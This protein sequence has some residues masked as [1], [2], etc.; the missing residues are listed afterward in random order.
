MKKRQSRILGLLL[1]AVMVGSS[2]VPSSALAADSAKSLY[3]RAV[4][5][6]ENDYKPGSPDVEGIAGGYENEFIKI[7]HPDKDISRKNFDPTDGPEERKKHESEVFADGLLDYVGNKRVEAPGTHPDAKGQGDR[8]QTYSW[9]GFAYGDWMYV[10]TLFSSTKTT[11]ELLGVE[12]SRDQLDKSYGGDLYTAEFDEQEPG[13][14]LSKINVK[15][16]EVKI[17][18]S[19]AKNGL[20][21]SFRSAVEYKDKLYFCGSVNHLPSIY[22]VDPKTDAFQCVYQD[23]SIRNHPGGPGQ[24]WAESLEK[25]ICPTIRGISVYK[26]YLVISTVGIDG[27]PYIAVSNDPSSGQFTKIASAWEDVEKKIPGELLGYPACRIQDSIMGGSIWEMVEF[28]DK[29]YVAIAT[30]TPEIA[31][32]NGGTHV[33]KDEDGN[34]VLDKDGNPVQ[35]IDEM[36]S[37]AIITGTFD[38]GTKAHPNSVDDPTAWTWE[39]LVGDKKDGAKYPFGIDPER[40]RSSACNM[41]V[42]KDKLYIGE[43]TDTQIAFLNMTGMEFDY[44]A[45]NLEQS[46][47]LY[48]MDKNEDIEKVMGQPTK[49]FPVAVSG[50]NESGFGRRENQYIWQ[51][52]VFNDKLYLGTFDETA[53][54]YPL[55]DAAKDAMS[56]Q[57]KEKLEKGL[58]EIEKYAEELVEQNKDSEI[59]QPT[60]LALPDEKV[61]DV[62]KNEADEEKAEIK[63]EVKEEAKEELKEEV[64]ENEEVKLAQSILDAKSFYE[65]R[66]EAGLL[67]DVVNEKSESL[68][69]SSL[70]ENGPMVEVES[71]DS[72][73]LAL[74]MINDMVTPSKDA[75]VREKLASAVQF[76]LLNEEVNAYVNSKAE[77]PSF[78]AET[79]KDTTG[80]QINESVKALLKVLQY[81][82]DCIPGFDMYVTEDGVHFKQITRSG[83]GDSYNQGLRVFAANN[84]KENPWLCIGTANPFY[85]TQIWRMEDKVMKKDP[86]DPKQEIVKVKFIRENGDQAERR[87]DTPDEIYVNEGTKE[88]SPDELTIMLPTDTKLKD[89][90][91]VKIQVDENGQKFVEVNVLSD[92]KDVTLRFLDINKAEEEQV[93]GT[94][95]IKVGRSK[96]AVPEAE[97]AKVLPNGYVRADE[98]KVEI[99]EQGESGFYADVPVLKSGEAHPDEK[100]SVSGVVKSYLSEKDEIRIDL[101]TAD[102][103]EAKYSTTV[104]GNDASYRLG[105]LEVGTYKMVVSK[106]D[107]APREYEIT[108]GEEGI[109]QDVEINPYGDVTLDGSVKMKDW[110]R[111]YKHLNETQELQGYGFRCADVNRDGK[112]N[113]QD[114]ERIHKHLDGSDL[115]W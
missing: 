107:H 34:V 100:I 103:Q 109:R 40:K 5:K 73:Y 113:M 7:S 27:N 4:G 97:I 10:S 13:S 14:T 75:S 12:F 36:Q 101:F 74:L 28:N 115:F 22:E 55:A 54:L 64:K 62:K 3:D 2:I 8:G 32:A 17:I 47:S 93:V 50:I 53:I 11:G 90:T 111:V 52:K 15:T 68:L 99:K 108:V 24:A 91:P 37:F 56:Q 16:G 79:V 78:M 71:P 1:A 98:N 83:L 48:R 82:Q 42:F 31:E 72:L 96:K 26:D 67:K 44:L 18:M 35:V 86:I 110:E 114:W 41:V 65:A 57:Q 38:E 19:G 43:Y 89:H 92:M 77:V 49:A 106:K 30:G 105:R 46:V 29:L 102:S 95:D 60:T 45:R 25:K 88:V 9:A 33:K 21:T 61:P 80:V 84:D 112:V 104:K 76:C 6:Y 81:L 66:K 59:V 58:Q 94:A 63:E 70:F 85:G 39:P 69:P 23:P 51:T 20:E 87:W